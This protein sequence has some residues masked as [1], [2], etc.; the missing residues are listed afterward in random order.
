MSDNIVAQFG[1][2]LR[3]MLSSSRDRTSAHAPL[4]TEAL[5]WENAALL[6]FVK[7]R[8]RKVKNYVVQMLNVYQEA[9]IHI[10]IAR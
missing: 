8:R 7:K 6:E 10:M 1:L 3:V 9:K 2:G 4:V 5:K